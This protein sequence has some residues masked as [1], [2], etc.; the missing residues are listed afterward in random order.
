MRVCQHL[1]L[2]GDDGTSRVLAHWAVDKMEEHVAARAAGQIAHSA[3]DMATAIVAMF[4]HY[5][6]ISYADVAARAAKLGLVE[7]AT[8]VRT[9]WRTHILYAFTYSCSTK[10]RSYVDK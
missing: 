5:P 3:Q 10:S 7:L 1:R 4:A 9:C 8:L 6:H 2:T